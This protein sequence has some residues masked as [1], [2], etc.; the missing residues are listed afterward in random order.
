[1]TPANPSVVEHPPD[2][3]EMGDLAGCGDCPSGVDVGGDWARWGEGQRCVGRGSE[4]GCGSSEWTG[5]RVLE[6]RRPVGRGCSLGWDSRRRIHGP[7][8][9]VG[10]HFPSYSPS[11]FR[12]RREPVWIGLEG[13]FQEFLGLE[14][15]R[16]CRPRPS[17]A[18]S[19]PTPSSSFKGAGRKTESRPT[20][21]ARKT[22]CL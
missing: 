20:L 14:E 15:G 13:V 19:L 22:R 2:V 3:R 10:D 5:V 11:L 8:E 18:F 7:L 12:T 4:E 1:M 17:S 6:G 21:A 16:R 9:R